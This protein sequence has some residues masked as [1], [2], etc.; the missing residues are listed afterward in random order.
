MRSPLLG[1]NHNLKYRGRVYHIQ[2]EDSGESNP[3]IFTHLF[4]NGI[5]ISTRKTEYGHLLGAENVEEQVR[6]LMQLQHK[7]MMKSLL[8]GQF[9]D[10]IVRYF[11]TLNGEEEATKTDKET[12]AET[13][14]ASL[15]PIPVTQKLDKTTAPSAQ[16]MVSAA[17]IKEDTKL[18]FGPATTGPAKSST[19]PLKEQP[20]ADLGPPT[21][22][23]GDL[24]R[25][26][27]IPV[28]ETEKNEPV[29][30]VVI[31]RPAIIL[32][33]DENTGFGSFA[34]NTQRPL[35]DKSKKV[36]DS[37]EVPDTLLEMSSLGKSQSADNS[38]P[39]RNSQPATPTIVP[40]PPT[41]SDMRLTG[42]IQAPP[43]LFK[44]ESSKE[45]PD[46]LVRLNTSD[47]RVD[48]IILDF[49]MAESLA[50]LGEDDENH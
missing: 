11:G 3:H 36:V 25:T 16:P 27:P 31:A 39:E 45:I 21:V 35:V 32:T 7:D 13:T 37:F 50:K 2:T 1:Y 38:F 33:G 14:P 28:N 4:H 41:T 23:Y 18:G 22:D 19:K 12:V 15:S 24:T 5:I 20:V 46:D 10:K 6:K 9:D 26:R 49:L 40:P 29:P 30:S 17:F 34:A 8:G 47:T 42:P 48:D 43:G 44:P